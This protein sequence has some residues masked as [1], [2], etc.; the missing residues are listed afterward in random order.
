[1]GGGN[2]KKAHPHHQDWSWKHNDPLGVFNG[3]DW[4][5][6]R[7]GRQIYTEV[8]APCHPLTRLTFNHFQAFMTKEEIKALAAQY[9]VID[10]M[11]KADG[12]DDVRQGKPTD[13]LPAP[14]PN[15]QAAAAANS[16][17]APPD[18]RTVLMGKEGGEDYV[19]ALLTGY[20]WSEYMEVPPWITVKPGQFFNPYFKGG[21]LAMPPPLSDGLVDYEDGTPA[22]TSQMAKDVVCFLQ[23]C[24]EPEY[25]ERRVC[26]WKAATTFGLALVLTWHAMDRSGTYSAFRR[27]TWRF[28]KKPW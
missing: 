5:S 23:W 3:L 10:A 9:E 15:Q 11:P 25:D 18:L 22:T 2:A 17:A 8:F 21:V 1:M 20:K 26:Y 16:G 7:R 6:I 4:K 24:M 27:S 28:W 13:W 14:Y 19:F 12:T